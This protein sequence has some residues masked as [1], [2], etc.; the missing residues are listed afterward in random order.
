[1]KPAIKKRL[2]D[3]FGE[4]D[5]ARQRERLREIRKDPEA[6]RLTRLMAPGAR[7]SYRYEDGGKDHTGRTVRFCWACHRNAAGYFLAWRENQAADGRGERVGMS[8]HRQKKAARLWSLRWAAEFR[9]G[10]RRTAGK[11]S[12]NNG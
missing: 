3:L 6:H 7:A 8:A 5:Q 1:M 2:D 12:R 11:R 10:I 9:A 4:Y